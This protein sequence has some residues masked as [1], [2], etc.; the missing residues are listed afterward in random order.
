MAITHYVVHHK[1]RDFW[2][3]AITVDGVCLATSAIATP[4]RAASVASVTQLRAVLNAWVPATV[5]AGPVKKGLLK[6]RRRR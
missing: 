3:W 6:S 4:T 5:R 1:C 2:H